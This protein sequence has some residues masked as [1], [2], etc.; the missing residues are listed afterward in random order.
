LKIEAPRYTLMFGAVQIHEVQRVYELD[1]G[2]KSI[3]SE[4][5]T[6]TVC[7]IGSDVMNDI[8][9]RM[10]IVVLTKNESPRLLEGVISGVPHD[11]LIIVVSNSERKPFDQY[12]NEMEMLKQ[13][14]QFVNR[15]II[16]I[17]QRDP[18]LYAAFK[19][20]G[21]TDI[22]H[23]KKVRSGKGEGV[24]VGLMLAKITK[25][26]YVGFVDADN[27][28]PGAVNEYVKNF[29][30]GFSLASSPYSMV[31]ISWLYKP[32]VTENGF[33]F[34]KWGRVNE[35]TN[36]Y[37]NRLISIRTGF[38]TEIIKTGN[39]SEYAISMKLAESLQFSSGSSIEPYSFLSVLENFGASF[40]IENKDFKSKG[41]QIFQVETRNPYFRVN[42]K[43]EHLGNML[44]SSIASIYHSNLCSDNLKKSMLNEL[45][46]LGLIMRGSK[47]PKPPIMRPIKNLDFKKFQEYLESHLKTLYITDESIF[48][49]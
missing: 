25:K 31:R 32:T 34:S 30:T 11:C 3:T 14:N 33:Y 39:S 28:V 8:E 36:K 16:L 40:S 44:L 9:G 15:K 2:S 48:Q 20:V 5:N 42:K 17:H 22:L 7:N 4:K 21:Y 1:S 47:L 19:E 45:I 43:D 23:G 41:V 29:D 35:Y 6:E 46:E 18:G 10:A 24:L 37:L 27:Y 12:R 38:G 26:E 49:V 13:F